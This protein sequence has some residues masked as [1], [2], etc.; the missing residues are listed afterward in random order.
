MTEPVVTDSTCLIGLE[1][2]DQLN[3]LPALFERIVA[4]PEVQREFGAVLPWL[5]IEIPLDEA[6]I[7]TLK[8]LVDDGEAEAIALASERGYKVVLDDRQARAV[9]KQLNIQIIGT[10]GILV[11]AK[12]SGLIAT[13][14]PVLNDLEDQ[15]FYV[16]N[17]LREEA[18]RIVGE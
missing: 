11:L 12:G 9:A 17:A 15:G 4:P 5:Q 13:L 8:I 2:I 1:R 14:R 6:L 18:L 3:L 7:A 10:I 16:G